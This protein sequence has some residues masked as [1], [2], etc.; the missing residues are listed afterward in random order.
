MFRRPL[1]RGA[2]LSAT[3]ARDIIPE[4][5]SQSW[6]AH[7]LCHSSARPQ[8]SALH[9]AQ[10]AQPQSFP[11]SEDHPGHRSAGREQWTTSARMHRHTEAHATRSWYRALVSISRMSFWW[12][13]GPY[14]E[15]P[16]SML[17]EK[18]GFRSQAH[19][20]REVSIEILVMHGWRNNTDSRPVAHAS[21]A[22]CPRM[23]R[24][25]SL[26]PDTQRAWTR[27]M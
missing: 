20:N 13:R 14:S 10:V 12:D 22:T 19:G 17:C 4:L 6:W 15:F 25:P 21:G 16:C 2:R 11:S 8:R 26:L 1:P 23:L 5:S 7:R 9:R 24:R 18:R 27:T 3:I